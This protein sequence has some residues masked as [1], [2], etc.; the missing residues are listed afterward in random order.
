MSKTN[1]EVDREN[2]EVRITRIFKAMPERLWRAYTDPEEVAQ[3]W[4]NTT[5]DKLDFKVGG[6][7]RFVDHGKNGGEN[8]GFRGV[9]KE[10]DEPRKIVRTFEYEPWAGHVLTESVIIEPQDDGKTLVTMVSKYD[11][12]EDLEGMVKSGMEKGA[13][14]G[15]ER[16]AKLVESA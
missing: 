11:N 2:L 14:A 16:I 4:R 13:T 3:W 1:F 5:I 10:I 9:F 6:E 15:I 7:W 12:L 8:H